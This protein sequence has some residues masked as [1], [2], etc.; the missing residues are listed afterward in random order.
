MAKQRAPSKSKEVVTTTPSNIIP[1]G[2]TPDYLK[3]AN[4]DRLGNLGQGDYKIPRILMLQALSPEIKTFQGEAI[5]G[6]FWH[7]GA[8]RSLGNEFNFVPVLVNKRVILW[9]P[10]H[11]GGGMLAFSRDSINWDMGANKT[12]EVTLR[13]KDKNVVKWATGKNVPTSGLLDWGSSNPDEENSAPAATLIY[14]YLCYLPDYPEL[15][16]CLF[17]V[18]KTALP[19]GKQLNTSLFMLRKPSASVIVR[20]WAIED[21]RDAG[22]FFN[23]QF[24]TAGWATPELYAITSKLA[25]QHKDY[26]AEY[27]QEETNTPA[28]EDGK[29]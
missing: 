14:E 18:T 16:P 13:S 29:Y 23:V 10:R 4:S 15:S 27:A 2:E 28:E 19:A 17:G 6:E 1:F 21:N 24:K 12:F 26:K 11:E 20:A 25:E 7:N 3:D 8:S 5:P 22:D 9:R